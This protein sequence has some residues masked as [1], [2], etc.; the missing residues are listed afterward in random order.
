MFGIGGPYARSRPGISAAAALLTVLA[1]CSSSSP[2]P[3]YPVSGTLKLKGEPASGAHVVFH[4]TTPIQ[5]PSAKEGTP[6][7]PVSPTAV[8]QP[9]GTFKVTSFV[10]GD[11][12]PAGDY[13]VTVTWLKTIT[14]NGQPE[15]GPNVIPPAYAKAESTPLKV[16]VKSESNTLEPWDIKP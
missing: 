7:E 13:S 9:D 4:P 6:G 1:A 11:G 10:G 2:L 14:K 3:V 5:L 15:A 16:T 12:A 8:V